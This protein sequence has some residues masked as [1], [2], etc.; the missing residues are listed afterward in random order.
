MPCSAGTSF[1]EL[2]GH[3]VPHGYNAPVCPANHCK[4][5]AECIVDEDRQF[6]CVCR[7]GFKGALCEINID[8]CVEG[9]GDAACGGKKKVCLIRKSNAH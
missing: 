3:C 7:K 8:E 9:G 4:N 1:D 2:Y 5:E 6:K